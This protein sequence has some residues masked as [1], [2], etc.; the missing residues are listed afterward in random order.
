MLAPLNIEAL[1]ETFFREECPYWWAYSAKNTKQKVGQFRKDDQEDEIMQDSWMQ[2][3]YLIGQYDYGHLM[4]KCKKN[5]SDTEAST[6]YWYVK[7][8]EGLMPQRSFAGRRSAAG[9][10]GSNGNM[11]M[12]MWPMM[13]FFMNQ[14]SQFHATQLQQVSEINRLNFENQR[15]AD[16]VGAVE[17]PSMQEY[18]LKE[19]FDALKLWI[20]PKIN[21]GYFQQPQQTGQLG[22]AGNRTTEETEQAPQ[23][24]AKKGKRTSFDA[25]MDDVNSAYHSLGKKYEPNEITRALAILCQQNPGPADQF[26]GPLIQQLRKHGQ[27]QG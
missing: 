15:L 24:P 3:E 8:G 9:M 19:T 23:P 12:G 18:M 7:W 11:N 26:L 27:S 2:L 14:Q 13:Q 20:G 5:P 1:Q 25:I 21:P 16:S 4:I 22:I 17:E 10:G 6:Q